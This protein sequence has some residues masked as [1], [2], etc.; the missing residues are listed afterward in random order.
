[1]TRPYLKMK[2]G[3]M[4]NGVVGMQIGRMNSIYGPTIEVT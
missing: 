1:M 4:M 2:H 3:M